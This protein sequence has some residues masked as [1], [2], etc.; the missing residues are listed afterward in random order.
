MRT[1]PQMNYINNS[2]SLVSGLV[3]QKIIPETIYAQRALSSLATVIRVICSGLAVVP[4]GMWNGK[5]ES[6][7]KQLKWCDYS[8]IPP[9][10]QT[11]TRAVA[12]WMRSRAPS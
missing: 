12:T 5:L 1:A 2:F 11:Q 7:I 4:N 10:V 8:E 3:I 6:R 9:H